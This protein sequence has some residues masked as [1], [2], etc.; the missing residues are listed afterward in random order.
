MEKCLSMTK[1]KIISNPY[2]EDIKFEIYDGTSEEPNLIQ[3]SGYKGNLISEKIQKGFFPFKVKEIL[4]ILKEDYGSKSNLLDV[5]FAGTSDEFDELK[6][7]W[8]NLNF[9]NSIRL[10]KTDDFLENARDILPRVVDIFKK[11]QPL[12]N[13]SVSKQE[14]VKKEMDKFSE[15][16]SADIPIY[17]IGNFS[18]GKS[19]LINAL[20]GYEFLPSSAKP[21]TAKIYKI[22][23]SEYEDRGEINLVL[24]DEVFKI[25]F[26][27]DEARFSGS[28]KGDF[29]NR[30]KETLLENSKMTLQVQLA[31]ALNMINTEANR[32]KESLIGDLIELKVP[33][34]D[35]GL[36]GSTGKRFV[37][38][39]TPGSDAVKNKEHAKVLKK[40][41]EGLSNGLPIVVSEY[42]SLDRTNADELADEIK[43]LEQLDD[44]FTMI[45]VNKADSARLSDYS[46]QEILDFAVPRKLYASGVY[47]VSSLIGLGAKNDENFLDEYNSEIFYDQKKKYVDKASNFYKQLYKYNILAD[48]IKERYASEA[49]KNSNLLFTN[50][51]LEEI[52]KAIIDFAKVYS[53]YNK[54]QQ[55]KKFINDIIGKT[56]EE[57]CTRRDELDGFRQITK[58]DLDKKKQHL[59]DKVIEKGNDLSYQYEKDYN[60]AMSLFSEGLITQLN[61]DEIKKED[62]EFREEERKNQRITEYREAAGRNFFNGLDNVKKNSN[63]SLKKLGITPISSIIKT[64]F[65]DF[66]EVLDS[67]NEDRN[68]LKIAK[69]KAENNAT[70]KLIKLIREDFTEKVNDAQT[71]FEK[72]SRN[73]WKES[74]ETFKNELLSLVT[75]SDALTIEE[76]GELKDL[77]IQYKDL[78]FDNKADLIFDKELF[79]YKLFGDSRKIDTTKLV[80][81]YNSEINNEIESIKENFSKSH[82]N[83]Y[84]DWSSAL[85]NIINDNIVEFSPSLHEKSEMIKD[86]SRQVKEL[87]DRLILL[88]EYSCQIKELMSW[89]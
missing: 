80:N 1:I 27:N 16:T 49:E 33:F 13:E 45:V 57:I 3:N 88:K 21:T 9:K 42:E 54:C 28:A 60:P 35:D 86:Y 24:N 51:G 46:E 62:R 64:A 8:N 82:V 14:L 20:I 23:Q 26:T 12:V 59:I 37:I 2:E 70:D 73:F 71:S 22:I 6:L 76:L 18:S 5:E 77:I 30:L 58:R 36:L 69:D 72:E 52:E 63:E 15:A 78:L 48:Q 39:D 65:N 17:V 79:R 19:T 11:I 40:A 89:K 56:S 25:Q 68:D 10:T 85:M 67:Y 87:E 41:L 38:F 55:S 29:I 84:R 47:F 4:D 81:K 61:P 34:D 53:P 44:R 43:G 66:N 50:S 75:D 32:H 31:E 7:I 74:S 83:S